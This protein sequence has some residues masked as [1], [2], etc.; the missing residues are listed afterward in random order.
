MSPPLGITEDEGNVSLVASSAST[1]STC[2]NGPGLKE[3]NYMSLSDCSS[4][5]SNVVTCLSEEK[6]ISLNLKATELRLGLPGSQSPVRDPEFLL[7]SSKK[8]DEKP[9]FPLHPSKDGSLSTVQ[10]NVSSGNKRGFSDAMDGFS[11]TKSSVFTETSWMFPTA[12]SEPEVP[13]SLVQG[14]FPGNQGVNSVLSSRPLPNSGAKTVPL[15]EQSGSSS[16][17][18]LKEIVPSKLSQDKQRNPND[19]NHNQ[20]GSANNNGNAPAAK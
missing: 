3:R 8:L 5:E 6:D 12:V 20:M 17:Q 19:G 10:K 1:D 15:K 13:Q 7:L 4:V 14:K 11:E 16:H 18:L 2:Q 9:L